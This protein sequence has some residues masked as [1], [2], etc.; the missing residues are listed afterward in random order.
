[1]AEPGFRPR[2]HTVLPF[3]LQFPSSKARPSPSP[4]GRPPSVSQGLPRPQAPRAQRCPASWLSAGPRPQLGRA[5][6]RA[7]EAPLR[8]LRLTSSCLRASSSSRLSTSSSARSQGRCPWGAGGGRVRRRAQAPLPPAPLQSPRR[9]SPRGSAS[10]CPRRA[11]PAGGRRPPRPSG[12]RRAGASSRP[13]PAAPG[14]SQPEGAAW[15][16]GRLG[17]R[18]KTGALGRGL[19]SASCAVVAVPA[20]TVPKPTLGQGAKSPC[21]EPHPQSPPPLAHWVASGTLLLVPAGVNSQPR[22]LAVGQPQMRGEGVP[23]A[24]AQGKDDTP[25]GAAWWGA[26][27]QGPA[28][29]GQRCSTGTTQPPAGGPCLQTSLGVSA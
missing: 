10:P 8:P 6:P 22:P 13:R 2:V 14:R 5:G 11:P 25:E 23:R 4:D 21:P 26:L 16:P 29:S 3:I 9:R 18:T 7:V 19:L 27:F 1:M 24:Q 12:L 15:G 28:G 20:V 17:S